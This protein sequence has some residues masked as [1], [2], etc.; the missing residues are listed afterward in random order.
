MK[1]I[2]KYCTPAKI[3]LGISVIAVVIVI[4]QNLLNNNLNELCIGELKC[5]MSHKIYVLV[6]KI[7]YIIFWTWFLN[8]LCK[9]GLKSLAWFILLIPFL[10][11][12][13]IIAGMIFIINE[14]STF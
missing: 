5:T 11:A 1:D 6:F 2:E 13:V 8:F 14:N 10:L 12:A 3:Y 7:I 9:K 4:G